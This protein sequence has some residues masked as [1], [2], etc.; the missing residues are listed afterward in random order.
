M[1]SSSR[2]LTQGSINQALLSIT[3]PMMFGIVAVI[4]VS[5]IDT[6]FVGKLGVQ[7][8]TALSFT[9]PVTMA[10]SSIAIGLGA[11]TASVV[12]RAVGAGNTEDA[13]R[14]TTDSLVLALI[15]VSILSVIGFLSTRAIFSSMGAEGIV[16]DMIVRYTRPSLNIEGA[17]YATVMA[18]VFTTVFAV[19][20]IVGREKMIAWVKPPIGELIHSWK[21]VLSV[22]LPASLGNA[23]NPIGVAIVTSVLAGFGEPTVAA[24]GVATRIE[25]LAAIPM[26]ALSAAIG[27]ISG[28]SWG[29]GDVQRVIDT[30]KQCY[31]VCLVWALIVAVFLAIFAEPL[32]AIFSS[33]PDVALGAKRYLMIV[34]ASLWGYGCVIVAAGGYNSLGKSVSGLG[35]YLVRTALLYVPLS[36][37]ASLIADS[38]AVYYAISLSNVLA[39]IICIYVSLHWLKMQNQLSSSAV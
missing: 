17:A 37:V 23:V 10:V 19:W 36:I 2:D 27:P 34:P 8:L 9:F 5:I 16:L 29:K 12:S 20:L 35:F 30:H 1:A 14:L 31:L 22:G 18:Q 11:G 24:F 33:E 39:G 38:E 7:E 21:R 4:S 28:Q 3:V 13:K 26:L 32:V 15:I 6:Y 25:A